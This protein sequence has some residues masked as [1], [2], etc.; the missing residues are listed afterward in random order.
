MPENINIDK[1]ILEN[2]DANVDKGILQNIDIEDLAYQTPLRGGGG[3]SA[4]TVSLTVK[5]PF[6]YDFPINVSI[7]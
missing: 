1:D 2:V 7:F 3:G 5:Y 6:F 4:L